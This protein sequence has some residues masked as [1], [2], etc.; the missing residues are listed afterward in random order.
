MKQLMLRAA[1]VLLPLLSFTASASSDPLCRGGIAAAAKRLG[2]DGTTTPQQR[3]QTLVKT[4][5]QDEIV[6]LAKTLISFQT[7]S[8]DSQRHPVELKKMSAFL[9]RWAAQH[10]FSFRA[11][12]K[13]DVFELARGKGPVKL[14]FVFHGDVVPAPRHEWTHDPFD[15]VVEDGKLIGRG[16][17]DDKGPLAAA[18]VSLA[19]AKAAGVTPD[20]QVRIIIGTSEENGWD[21]MMAYAKSAPKAEHTISVDAGF[22]VIAGQSGF[23]A[24][25]LTATQKNEAGPK[26]GRF[27]VTDMAAG[28]FLTQVPGEARMTLFLSGLK[29]DAAL[30][31]VHTAIDELSRSRQDFHA[32]VALKDGELIVTTHGKPVHSSVAEQGHN[33][34][35]D[36]AALAV[37]LDVRETP[38]GRL[39]REVAEHF[40]GDH[41]GKKLGV[42]YEDEFMGPLVVSPNV[43]RVER[44]PGTN[45]AV[46]TLAVNMRR[47]QGRDNATFAASLDAAAKAISDHTAGAVTEVVGSR[48][49]GDPHLADTSGPLVETL[50]AIYKQYRGGEDA[51]PR[52]IRGGTYARLFDGAVDFG[53]GFPGDPVT[54]HGADEWISVD[55]LGLLAQMLSEAVLRLAVQP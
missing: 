24:W 51:K 36:L 54:A 5:A 18:L 29:E 32:D 47:P 33:A 37:K 27:T 38:F 42:F 7:V 43:L 52:S 12:G 8:A 35:W 9:R 6:P 20:G 25:T 26:D 21:A 19:A 1:L 46:A 44:K 48:H 45:E 39:L 10:G 34:L 4:C 50:T 3:Y 15:A 53:P 11:I 30:K 31:R 22:P 40:D 55:H 13:N 23:V 2:A 17:D 28:E 14:A 41:R 49:I 16:A